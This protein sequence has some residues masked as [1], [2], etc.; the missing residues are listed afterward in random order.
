MSDLKL[1]KA[2]KRPSLEEFTA[3]H[4][5]AELY[6]EFFK[7]HEEQLAAAYASGEVTDETF[8][9]M[10]ADK[11]ARELRG[12]DELEDPLAPVF[13]VHSA[14]RS[15]NTRTTRAKAA[16]H[17]RL[18]QF[19]WGDASKRVVRGRPVRLTA[20]EVFDHIDELIAKEAA[21]SIVVLTADRR[22]LD[23]QAVKRGEFAAA[24]PG[25]TAPR[26]NPPL[27]S[28]ANDKPAGELMPQYMGGTFSGDP[29]A[30]RALANAAQEKELEA[31]RK[32]ATDPA[33]KAEAPAA[34]A[35]VQD[36]VDPAAER[37]ATGEGGAAAVD[38]VADGKVDGAAEQLEQQSSVEGAVQPEGAPDTKVEPPPAQGSTE[39]QQEQVASS[40]SED[41]AA[42]RDTGRRGG[43]RH[44]KGRK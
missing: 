37:A 39:T 9:A 20:K 35:P 8:E 15:V 24:E 3:A 23:L 1:P 28:A 40:D 7:A 41:P 13:F 36:F 27:D 11:A 26:P 16:G 5:K 43:P 22:C 32:E 4:Y 19:L 44:Q 21:G 18:I 30:E 14:T 25:A 2:Y 10:L 33:A 34:D 12:G 6:E 31:E 29:A 17:P 38:E 42:S